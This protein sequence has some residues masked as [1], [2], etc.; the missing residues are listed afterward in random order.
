L[1]RINKTI[2]DRFCAYPIEIYNYKMI[3]YSYPIRINEQEYLNILI[4]WNILTK[5]NEPKIIWIESLF[6]MFSLKWF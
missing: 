4:A 1:F 5:M 3:P 6:Q 2:G